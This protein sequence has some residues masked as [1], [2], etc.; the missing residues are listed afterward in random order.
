MDSSKAVTATFTKKG[1]TQ[2]IQELIEKV[3]QYRDSREIDNDGIANSLIVKLEA[4]KA[5]LDSGN[6]KA[7]ANILKAFINHV[8]AQHRPADSTKKGKHITEAAAHQL[9][10]DA[11]TILSQL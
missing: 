5:Q 2:L 9:I 4:A 1:P 3:E 7:A 11:E 6:T 8:E 10:A